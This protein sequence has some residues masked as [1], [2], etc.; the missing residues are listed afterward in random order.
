MVSN[1]IIQC[2]AFLTAAVAVAAISWSPTYAADPLI[3]QIDG[4]W[5]TIAGDPDLGAFTTDFQQPVDFSIW[6]ARD[7]TWQLWSCIRQT[8]IGGYSRLFHRWQGG[9]ITDTDWRPMGIAMLADPGFGETPGGLQAP[10]V[11][12]S[13]RTYHMLYG[14]WNH[15]CAAKGVDGKTFARQLTPRG[16]AGMFGEPGANPRD[17]MLIHI[18]DLWHCYYTA[19]PDNQ[20]AVYCRTS[21]DLR[22]WGPAKI[23]AAGGK[24]GDGPGSAECSH[25]IYL[26]E[27][28]DYYLFRTQRYGQEGLTTVY[29]STDPMN[30][31]INDDSKLACELPIA[32][33]E[34]ILFDDNF[35]IAA[36]LPNLKGIRVARL[37]WVPNP[38]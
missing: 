12:R 15:I 28:G 20:G 2:R 35:Y 37:I 6:R 19:N 17:P 9:A 16:L 36:L 7:G 26:H 33:P 5:W 22:D 31:G 4:D 10:H 21:K 29:R 11:V 13:D 23:V 14:D 32:A 25:V 27:T 8:R 38:E 3:P 30:F 34:I 18:G 24:A 1:A